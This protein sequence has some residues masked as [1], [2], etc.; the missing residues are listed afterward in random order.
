MN[1]I[2]ENLNAESNASARLE[3]FRCAEC[4]WVGIHQDTCTSK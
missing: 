3:K 1:S 2:F 4:R